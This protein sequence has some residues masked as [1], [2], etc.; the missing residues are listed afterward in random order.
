MRP[1]SKHLAK[2]SAPFKGSGRHAV[3][4][5]DP[6]WMRLLMNMPFVGVAIFNVKSQKWLR[7]NDRFC[8]TVGYD[9]RELA[10]LSWREIC[11]PEDCPASETSLRR[12]A[13]RRANHVKI[14]QRLVRKDGS[15]VLVEID[16]TI[17]PSGTAANDFAIALVTETPAKPATTND[18]HY[19]RLSNEGTE[20]MRAREELL[21]SERKFRAMFDSSPEAMA[22]ARAQDGVMLEVNDALLKLT[23][24]TREEVIGHSSL[25]I[26]L[27]AVPGE[28]E[29]VIAR[30]MA[31]RHLSNIPVRVP[32]SD[33]GIVE[34][35]CSYALFDLDDEPY[36]AWLGRDIT[37]QRRVEE[38]RR[39]A[40][41]MYRA[42]FE[43][44]VKYAAGS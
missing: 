35:L 33:G 17:A 29:A 27:W 44:A 20:I 13:L 16:A 18:S 21:T 11:H 38:A 4:D 6:K 34:V 36:I 41:A 42:I 14:E 40:E 10:R 39:E 32:R 25:E 3:H 43:N 31:E 15:I 1:F 5:L 23:G 2:K 12:L 26:P 9:R 8:A 7:F 19:R 37:E 30:L 28:R 22:I 24:R